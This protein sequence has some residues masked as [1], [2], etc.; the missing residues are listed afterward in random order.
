[1]GPGP[2]GEAIERALGKNLPGNF[3]VFDKFQNGVATSIKS[4]NL[5]DKTY[6]TA[7][8]FRNLRKYVDAVEE[9][10][11]STR[12]GFPLRASE[13]EQR[14]MQIAIPRRPVS[15]VQAKALQGLAE[16]GRLRGVKVYFTEV[17]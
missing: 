10:Q 7:Q 14:A 4:V 12:G 2:R 8:G 15:S 6:S 11:Q 5:A 17:H 16:Y 13:I 3:D 9:F 1:M